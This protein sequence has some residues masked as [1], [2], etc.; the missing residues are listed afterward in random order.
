MLAKNKRF[1]S[2]IWGYS[3]EMYGLTSEENY[4]LNILKIAKSLGFKPYVITKNKEIIENDANLDKDITIIEYKNIFNY[5]YILIRFSLQNS[6]FYV[7]SLELQSFIVPFLSRKTIF[8]AHT[9]P[10]RKTLKKQR[11]QNFIYR[12]FS[13]IRLNNETE[14]NFLIDQKVDQKKLYIIPLIVSE[15]IFKFT[16]K[17]IETRKDL[18]YFG[19][20]TEIKN[21]TTI[22]K[23]LNIVKK[24][25][26]EIKL[27]IVGKILYDNFDS[28]IKELNLEENIILHGYLPQN[29]Y[30][31]KILN[32]TLI[33]LNSSISEGQCVSV[34][35]TALS[36]NVLCLPNIMSFQDV[37]RNKAL[38]HDIYDHEK[39]AENIL[40]YLNNSDIIEKYQKE[41]IE[42]IKSDYSINTIEKK[43]KDLILKI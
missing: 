38:F 42:M 14:K 2:I 27:H 41:C 13:V 35:N 9:Q 6:L 22:L 30:L 34:Y 40:R 4:H 18:L 8:M 29:E 25:Y 39:L 23:S 16:N 36:G 28:N 19:N 32:S 21:M 31:N 20:V 12:F 1:I 7:N 10:K 5:I 24:Q 37:F 3:K 17:D 11:I 43:L 33:S 26:P 15:N